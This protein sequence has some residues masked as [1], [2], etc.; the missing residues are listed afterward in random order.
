MIRKMILVSYYYLYDRDFN[1]LLCKARGYCSLAVGFNTPYYKANMY[2][3]VNTIY[4]YLCTHFWPVLGSQI[5]SQFVLNLILMYPG[6]FIYSRDGFSGGGG[7]VCTPT[8][9]CRMGAIFIFLKW[10]HK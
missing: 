1:M 3:I 9:G 7:G 6:T 4:I 10:V 8:R 5:T 2:S